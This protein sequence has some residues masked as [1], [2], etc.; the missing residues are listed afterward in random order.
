MGSIWGSLSGGRW[1]ADGA[2]WVAGEAGWATG[3]VG[4]AAGR[5]GWLGGR[6]W[7]GWVGGWVACASAA[8]QAHASKQPIH[9]TN[10]EGSLQPGNPYNALYYA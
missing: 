4:W 2:G 3:G 8:I 6:G 10:V 9:R 1:A 5:L 7:L